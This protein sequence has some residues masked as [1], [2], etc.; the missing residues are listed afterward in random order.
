M[1]E[2]CHKWEELPLCIWYKIISSKEIENVY[3]LE[4]KIPLPGNSEKSFQI[5]SSSNLQ[6]ELLDFDFFNEITYI[7]STG[8]QGF[9]LG[10]YNEKLNKFKKIW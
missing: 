7:R 1:L 10:E 2:E 5:F 8:E 3:I 9:D 4:L 6:G